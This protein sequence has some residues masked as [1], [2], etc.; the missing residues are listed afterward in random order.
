MKSDSLV[1][2]V[3]R[4][5]RASELLTGPLMYGLV[6][7]LASVLFWIPSP[8]GMVCIMTL[9]CGDGVADIVGRRLG[10]TNPLP[11]NPSKSWA[12]S[13]AFVLVGYLSCIGIGSL[14]F[15]WGMLDPKFEHGF[16]LKCSA[17]VLV[18][19]LAESLP[20]AE[21]DNLTVFTACAVCGKIVW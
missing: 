9:C 4:S 5:G 20:V 14:F 10:R 12:G 15:S 19:A 17:V 3:S 8:I 1:A 6:H 11:W 2:V 18:G 7:I 16:G 21:V 13:V